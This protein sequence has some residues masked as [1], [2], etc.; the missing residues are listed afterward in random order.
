MSRNAFVEDTQEVAQTLSKMQ[1]KTVRLLKAPASYY[2][3]KRMQEKGYVKNAKY[4]MAANGRTIKGFALTAKG[5][6][7]IQR[8]KGG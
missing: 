6:K 1:G 8:H 4:G 2:L 3:M 7:L 5:E